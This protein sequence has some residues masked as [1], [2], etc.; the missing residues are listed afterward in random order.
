MDIISKKKN[1]ILKVLLGLDVILLLIA[2]FH[3][4]LPYTVLVILANM[5]LVGTLLVLNKYGVI[6][7]AMSVTGKVAKGLN[8]MLH[9]V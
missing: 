8:D 3:T 7:E 4:S 9:K 5:V 2:F 6:F 1:D